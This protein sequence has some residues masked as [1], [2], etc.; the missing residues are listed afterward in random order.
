MSTSS[1]VRLDDYRGKKKQRMRQTLALHRPDPTRYRLVEHLHEVIARVGGDRAAVLWVDEYG[2]GL[3]H[4][5]C[6]LDLFSDAPRSTF[7]STPLR[8]AWEHGIPGVIDIPDSARYEDA[9][10]AG[11]RSLAGVALGSDGSRAWFMVVDGVAARAELNARARGNLMFLAGEC[12]SVVLHRDESG[13]SAG[14][15]A[16]QKRERE[17]FRGWA[18][19]KD[20]EGHEEDEALNRR[21]ASRFLV[22]RAVRGF[23]D[24]DLAM[25]EE[26]LQFQLE[27]VRSELQTLP[28]GDPEWQAWLD[29]LDALAEGDP[30]ELASCTLELANC[31][32]RQDHLAGALELY[33]ISYRLAA[34][35]GSPVVA[36][37]AARFQGRVLRR[38]ALWDEATA[39]Y[40][41]AR[42]VAHSARQPGR[43]SV[44][45]DGLA[46]TYRDRGNLPG[47]REL[48]EQAL[49]LGRE[50]KDKYAEGSVHHSLA[51]VERLMGRLDRAIVH[52]W[53]AVRIHG[54]G[55]FWV[56]ALTDL[57][58][59]FVEAGELQAAED[60]YTIVLGASNRYIYRAYALD[61]LAYI[62]ALRGDP[63][64]FERRAARADASGWLDDDTAPAIRAEFSYFRGKSY[65]ALG[66]LPSARV[67]YE[68]SRSVANRHGLNKFSYDAE[69]ALGGLSGKPASRKKPEPHE[70]VPD[71][72]FGIREEL[73]AMREALS[74]LAG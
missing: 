34:A 26:S 17:G 68:R 51:V 25:P 53:S 61:A 18:V 28:P 69:T 48:L 65:Q 33:R 38:L 29:V 10:P 3:V 66:D 46:S 63:S 6:L 40:G 13:S 36:I 12:A 56:A 24:D 8:E 30:Q 35:C 44:V 14:G 50:A 74:G 57:A 59:V 60:A 58:G 5:H 39:W 54:T 2:P 42:E 55:E 7:S 43:E 22:A 64:E 21:I 27:N 41:F 4:V 62:A 67:W 49:V 70:T 31:I 71:V 47:A 16:D 11:P 23:V 9:I 45:L 37:D 15:R 19:L 20:I 1:V 32:E 73:T 52:G 72:M